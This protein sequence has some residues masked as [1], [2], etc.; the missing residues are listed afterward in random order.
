VV[1]EYGSKKSMMGMTIAARNTFLINPE[2]QIVK[3]WTGV[4]PNKHSVEVLA[5]LNEL[6][7]KKSS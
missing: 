2:G 1:E 7:G 6:Q 4:D 5:A 3:V